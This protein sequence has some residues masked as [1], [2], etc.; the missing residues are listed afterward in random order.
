MIPMMVGGILCFTNIKESSVACSN[1]NKVCSPSSSNP[2]FSL[3]NKMWCC[4][5]SYEGYSLPRSNPEEMPKNCVAM[6]SNQSIYKGEP[7]KGSV[8]S[9]CEEKKMIPGCNCYEEEQ[10]QGKNK[11]TVQ[12]CK[13]IIIQGKKENG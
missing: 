2:D 11:R 8:G 7:A 13:A 5:K 1:V 4:E 3:C 6:Y 10:R 9:L 12:V